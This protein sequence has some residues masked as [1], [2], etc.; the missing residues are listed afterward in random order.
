MDPACSD[1][2]H[3]EGKTLQNRRQL[4]GR[5]LGSDFSYGFAVLSRVRRT[6][7]HSAR[8]VSLDR[9]PASHRARIRAFY[10]KLVPQIRELGLRRPR[11][12]ILNKQVAAG[13]GVL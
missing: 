5:L 8:E 4:R 13:E 1:E 2:A 9:L 11:E 12:A 7:V 6:E 10:V 3:T